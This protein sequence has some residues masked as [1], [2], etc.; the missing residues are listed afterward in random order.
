MAA[1]FNRIAEKSVGP[2]LRIFSRE[3]YGVF[4][5]ESVTP[6]VERQFQPGM[7]GDDFFNRLFECHFGPLL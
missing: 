4:R 2:A 6:N 3:P 1:P 5:P 7:L